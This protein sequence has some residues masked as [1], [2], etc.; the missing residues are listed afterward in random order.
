MGYIFKIEVD[1]F[2][3]DEDGYHWTLWCR[4]SKLPSRWQICSIG[5]AKTMQE[6]WNE[7]YAVQERYKHIK[8]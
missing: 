6:A 3:L 2:E 8:E 1:C 4:E 5:H 7:A